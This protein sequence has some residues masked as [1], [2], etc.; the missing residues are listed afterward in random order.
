MQCLDNR[1]VVGGSCTRANTL[2]QKYLQCRITVLLGLGLTRLF[3][4][5]QQQ[6][7]NHRL[8]ATLTLKLARNSLLK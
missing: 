5:L 2:Q 3:V 7:A 1:F 8:D 6:W 4:P